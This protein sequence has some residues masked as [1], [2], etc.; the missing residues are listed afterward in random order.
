MSWLTYDYGKPVAVITGG[1]LHGQPIRLFDPRLEKKPRYF[2]EDPHFKVFK[3]PS[4]YHGRMLLVPH[5]KEQVY[6]AGVNGCGK[7]TMISEYLKLYTKLF[8][9]RDIYLFS[10]L[11]EDPLLDKLKNIYRIPC[12]QALVDEPVNPDD[13]KG[14]AVVFDDI[15]SIQDKAVL[16]AVYTLRDSLL[17]I[18]RHYDINVVCTNHHV[19]DRQATRT[20]INESKILVLFPGSGSDG[21]IKQTLKHYCGMTQKQIDMICTLNGDEGGWIAI[22]KNHPLYVVWQKGIMLL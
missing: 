16:K 12:D 11:T 18:S 8:P 2:D 1:D 4:N 22:H 10:H 14:S 21:Q 5:D 17:R 13:L 9:D 3:L 20:M 7:S 6:A 19:N 15:D